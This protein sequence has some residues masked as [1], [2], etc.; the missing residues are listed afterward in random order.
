ML[1]RSTMALLAGK[2]TS[3]LCCNIAMTVSDAVSHCGLDVSTRRIGEAIRHFHRFR[4][5]V[6]SADLAP[7][8]LSGLPERLAGFLEALEKAWF[9]G[10]LDF[11]F[12]RPLSI[13]HETAERISRLSFEMLPK[14]FKVIKIT[15]LIIKHI[16]NN[17]NVVKKNP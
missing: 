14:S 4:Q 12:S 9:G 17:I 10:I 11:T 1:F 6:P 16:D 2:I 7:A 15:G 8:S 13:S 3:H 5:K